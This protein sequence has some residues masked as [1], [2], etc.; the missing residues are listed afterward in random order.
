MRRPSRVSVRGSRIEGSLEVVYRQHRIIYEVKAS[1][2][3]ILTIKHG[4]Q[5]LGSAREELGRA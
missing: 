3:E 4:R 5:Q 1:G 2:V